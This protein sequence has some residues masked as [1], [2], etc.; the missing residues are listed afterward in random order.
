MEEEVEEVEQGE[1]NVNQEEPEETEENTVEELVPQASKKKKKDERQYQLEEEE[2]E[3][4]EEE[5]EEEEET[6]SLFEQL[7]DSYQQ[8]TTQLQGQDGLENVL[9]EYERL[10]DAA[11]DW[12]E[13][14][15]AREGRAHALQVEA[16][17]LW[18]DLID[19][20][21]LESLET[22][23]EHYRDDNFLLLPPDVALFIDEDT[24]DVTKEDMNHLPY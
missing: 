10:F 22:I 16:E 2:E 4:E 23:Y 5:V 9:Q 1:Q 19:L 7:F 24:G 15:E 18:G 12:Y 8:V 13:L 14:A 3:E 11:K 17:V 6:K 20:E 21:V